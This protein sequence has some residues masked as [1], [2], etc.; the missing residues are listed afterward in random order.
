MVAFGL[1]FGFLLDNVKELLGK[2]FV[3]IGGNLGFECDFIE[4]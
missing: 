2:E 1:G 4:P 3:G